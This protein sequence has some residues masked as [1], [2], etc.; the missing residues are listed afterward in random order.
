MSIE[1]YEVAVAPMGDFRWLI[2]V[3]TP[4]NVKFGLFLHNVPIQLNEQIAYQIWLQNYKQ[5]FIEVDAELK[6]TIRHIHLLMD[7]AFNFLTY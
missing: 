5:F 6:E 2:H 7:K 3:T 4:E 1:G